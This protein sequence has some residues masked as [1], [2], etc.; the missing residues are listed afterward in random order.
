MKPLT[1]PEFIGLFLPPRHNFGHGTDRK[2][3][4]SRPE[5]TIVSGRGAIDH[6]RA[7]AAT[8]A[9]GQSQAWRER[10]RPRHH[11]E[12]V[13]PTPT[14]CGPVPHS[15]A[16]IAGSLRHGALSAEPH[17][18]ADPAPQPVAPRRPARL[19]SATQDPW[20]DSAPKLQEQ[21]I[22][23]GVVEDLGGP[24][25]TMVGWGA[26]PALPSVVA[27]S[28]GHPVRLGRR[29]VRRRARQLGPGHGA[30]V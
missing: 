13:V 9:A 30:L 11:T 27:V 12:I 28:A 25:L 20:L 22:S 29:R 8:V 1:G 5:L 17:R 4:P 18:A 7:L 23:F 24:S 2:T 19:W 15:L 16:A 21:L 26:V 6:L 14:R 3:G 10:R